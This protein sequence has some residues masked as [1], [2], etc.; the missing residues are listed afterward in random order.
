MVFVVLKCVFPYFSV[1]CLKE[2]K[3]G[4]GKEEFY[5]RVDLW[6]EKPG[7]KVTA[8][9][10]GKG[11]PVWEVQKIKGVSSVSDPEL[12]NNMEQGK[13]ISIWV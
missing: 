2:L 9:S 3:K 6:G 7:Q 13:V 10:S 8:V 11:D 5:F 12:E 4:L 1:I